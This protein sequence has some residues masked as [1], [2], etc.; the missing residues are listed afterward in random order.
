MDGNG[1]TRGIFTIARK[2]ISNTYNEN[3][4]PQSEQELA[5][6]FENAPIGIHWLGTDGTILKV[7]QTELD[8]LGYSRKEFIGHNITEFY[9]DE[10]LI[11]SALQQ[12]NEGK[13]I[14]NCEGSMIRNDGSIRHIL[15]SS[16]IY[17]KNDEFIHTRCFTLDITER[18]KAQQELQALNENLEKRVEERTETLKGYQD[19]LRKLVTQLTEAEEQERHR[20]AGELH[21]NLGQILSISK[22]K[23]NALQNEQTGQGANGLND[24]KNL[25]D[26]ALS[27]TRGLMSDLIPP[28]TLDDQDLIA[29]IK[30]VADKMTKL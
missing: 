21:D 2:I 25:I 23:V 10:Q 28:P 12:L 26:D 5:D 17:R 14:H 27:Y 20:L 29:S 30:W 3:E 8:M 15:L 19:H 16:N 22:M 11:K 18:K 13:V 7:N 1:V 24:L 9:A 6:F 4:L